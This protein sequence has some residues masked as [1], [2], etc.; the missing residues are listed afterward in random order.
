MF[1]ES[2]RQHISSASK[3]ERKEKKR[4]TY[5]IGVD[6]QPTATAAVVEQLNWKGEYL[7]SLGI[8]LR[9]AYL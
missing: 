5:L 7:W 2:M 9:L 6:G 4:L 1:F 8:L 3:K